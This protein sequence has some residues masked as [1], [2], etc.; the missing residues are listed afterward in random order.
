MTQV[1]DISVPESNT[2]TTASGMTAAFM[3]DMLKPYTSSQ[4]ASLSACLLTS[5]TATRLMEQIS[6][7][8]AKQINYIII[9]MQKTLKRGKLNA[10]LSI[11][12]TAEQQ[13]FKCLSLTTSLVKICLLKSG[14]HIHRSIAPEI[15]ISVD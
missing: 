10:D 13:T 1:S 9:R 3:Q 14:V 11:E 12:H 5:P 8:T 7:Y 6:G 4:K 15:L 2:S